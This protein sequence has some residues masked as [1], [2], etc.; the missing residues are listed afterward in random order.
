MDEIRI[1]SVVS[2]RDRLAIA[3]ALPGT[4]GRQLPPLG[5]F[6]VRA[7]YERHVSQK[8]DNLIKGAGG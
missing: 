7:V 6:A 4:F 1:P 2:S 8:G 3:L 5:L